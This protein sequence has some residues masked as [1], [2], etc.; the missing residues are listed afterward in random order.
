MKKPELKHNEEMGRICVC[1][2]CRWMYMSDDPFKRENPKCS[3]EGKEGVM[4]SVIFKKEGEPKTI[5][6]EESTLE[7][8]RLI[9]EM[10]MT[11]EELLAKNFL[12]AI[13]TYQNI[14]RMLDDNKMAIVG[15]VIGEETERMTREIDMLKG[16]DKHFA[17]KVDGWIADLD[18]RI[19]LKRREPPESY[20]GLKES[21]VRIEWTRKEMMR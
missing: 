5:Q 13:N 2:E 18:R 7:H 15:A 16:Q 10:L 21:Q 20:I 9:M 19:L 1:P 8:G 14:V 12:K 17:S 6:I 4:C 3:R 11:R